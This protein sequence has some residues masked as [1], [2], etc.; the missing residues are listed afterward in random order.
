MKTGYDLINEL[1]NLP[2]FYAQEIEIKEKEI[3]IK[4]ENP[5]QVECPHCKKI[6][7]RIKRAK[8]KRI[9]HKDIF[10]K[11]CYLEFKH[12]TYHCEHC[13]LYF[14][15]K[16]SYVNISKHHSDEFVQEIVNLARGSS[17]KHVCQLFLKDSVPLTQNRRDSNSLR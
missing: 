7:S 11:S 12:A 2:D 6:A 16:L 5:K 14:L 8:R 4:G 10:G 15:Q 17:L 1:L 3:V 13:R 9:R